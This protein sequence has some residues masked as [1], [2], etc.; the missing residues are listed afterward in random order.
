[1]AQHK[2]PKV[3]ADDLTIGDRVLANLRHGRTK[4]SIIKAITPTTNGKQFQV[5]FGSDQTALIEEWQIIKKL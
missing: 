2:K 3:N 5:D 1:M 4:E